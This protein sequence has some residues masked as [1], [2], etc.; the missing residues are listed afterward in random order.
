MKG[1]MISLGNT[2]VIH[3]SSSIKERGNGINYKDKSFAK[4]AFK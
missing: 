4:K 3:T 2:E 1:K